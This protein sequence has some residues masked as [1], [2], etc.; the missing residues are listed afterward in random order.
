L[1]ARVDVSALLEGTLYLPPLAEQMQAIEGSARLA[2]IRA[3]ADEYETALWDGTGDVAEIVSNI[4]TINQEDRFEDWIE[5]LPFPL[6]S[7]LWLHRAGG[8]SSRERYEVLLQF[9]EATAAFLATLHLSAFMASDDLWHQHGK[10]LSRKLTQQS[11]SFDRITF[12]TWKLV[13]EYL[14]SVC[15]KLIKDPGNGE[16]WQRIYGTSNKMVLNMLTDAELRGVLQRANRIRND[17]GH[18]GAVSSQRA[19]QID[20]ELMELTYSLRSVFGRTW[21]GY[22]LIQPKDARYKDG[23]HHYKV[24]RLMGTRSA[25]FEEV[26]RESLQPLESDD[27]YLF[28]SASRHGL[29]LQPFVR[30]MPSPEKQ[31][32][33]C[34]IFSRR[35]SKGHRFVSYH[36]EAESEIE[37]A[38]PEV[39]VALER[40]H[41][42]DEKVSS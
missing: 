30:V 42:F 6:A 40:L 9:F 4:A 5:T 7:I 31:A 10:K 22:E 17:W 19:K 41:M 32:N 3:A 39:E 21:C 12:G 24:K 2:S 35:E 38:F 20:D 16:V 34:F 14:S 36:F 25:P 33:A 37:D 15:A 8:R 29:R 28:D 23:V 1:L 13:A 27:L 26:E 11:M 18:G